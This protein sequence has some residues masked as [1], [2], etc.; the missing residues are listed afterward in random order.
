MNDIMLAWF[1]GKLFYSIFTKFAFVLLKEKF[2]ATRFL[3]DPLL[4]NQE[5]FSSH[6][7]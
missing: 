3:D 7:D 4:Q 1:I 5:L 2:L 6:Y